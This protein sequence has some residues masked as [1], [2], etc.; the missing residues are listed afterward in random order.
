MKI[1]QRYFIKEVLKT[2]LLFLAC[3]YGLY[4]LI[5]YASHA[6]SFHRG[7]SAFSWQILGFYY[8]LEFVRHLEILLPFALVLA[9]IKTLTGL[10]THHELVALMASGVK[11]KTLLRPFILLAVA[12]AALLYLNTEV[13]VPH[14]MRQLKVLN[15][16]R[17]LTKER[18]RTSRVQHLVLEDGSTVLYQSYDS[19][20]QYF[21]DAYWIR[22]LN[23]I[24]RIKFLYPYT[25]V[26]S[27]HFVDVLTRQKNGNLTVT[28]SHSERAFPGMKF[29]KQ[30]LFES[31][32]LPE[33][34]S[35]SDLWSKIPSIEEIK[36]EK[37][38]QMLTSFYFKL[39][40]PWLSFLAVIAAAPFCVRFSRTQPLFYI[41][42][43][44]IFGLV[45][46]QI[47]M[48]SAMILGERQVLP[49]HWAIWAPFALIVFFFSYR[50]QRIH[51]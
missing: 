15:D 39:A 5:D 10:N 25:K 22:S 8:L 6:S 13:L 51:T 17:A 48:D 18:N 12:A 45:A 34:L 29:N 40:M 3:F 46:F 43:L 9:T 19:S 35:Y 26:P 11:L 20:Q 28:T 44:S 33:E 41:Y 7:A 21:F 32:T 30:T 37:Q 2:A 38:A 50:Y 24:Y 31:M 42:A 1:W 47:V 14:A 23:E 4:V 36:S 16:A 49:P 27:G